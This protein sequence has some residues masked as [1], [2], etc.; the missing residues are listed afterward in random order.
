M[1][2]ARRRTG[3]AVVR[4]R[5]RSLCGRPAS[6]GRHR[7]QRG[8]R[9]PSSGGRRRLLH[10]AAAARGSL[11]HDSHAR[12][13]LDHA[14]ARRLDRRD[15]GNSGRGRR[16]RGH[17]R[18]ERRGRVGR[19]V[20]PPGRAPDRRSERLR[21]SADASAGASRER[22]STAPGGSAVR[23]AGSPRGPANPGGVAG[24]SAAPVRGTSS[25]RHEGALARAPARGRRGLASA[26]IVGDARVAGTCL[27]SAKRSVI[28][29]AA[30]PVAGNSHAPR[31]AG[32]Q[33]SYGRRSSRLAGTSASDGASGRCNGGAEPSAV[34]WTE[35]APARGHGRLR[36][37]A[38]RARSCR[39]AQA[40]ARPG[41]V[42]FGA[43]AAP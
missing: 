11:P 15:Y 40:R 35:T 23:C 8:R 36:H 4:G 29:P 43:G 9:A 32:R 16:R 5:R 19:A 7:R 42:R 38:P 3:P 39:A 27:A 17:D 26:G 22:A 20:R 10:R 37:R 24:S 14:R 30:A 6:R 12:R 31:R 2:V 1:G 21:R 41:P 34:A 18:P 13:L 25:A 33:A 28:V